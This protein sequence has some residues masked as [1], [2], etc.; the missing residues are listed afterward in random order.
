MTSKAGML[1]VLTVLVT[2]FIHHQLVLKATPFLVRKILQKSD[3]ISSNSSDVIDLE[4]L[5]ELTMIPFVGE[6]FIE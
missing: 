6:F 5:E 1:L 4:T 2:L 3:I